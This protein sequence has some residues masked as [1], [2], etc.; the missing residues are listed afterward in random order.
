MN[1]ID[2]GTYNTVE[3]CAEACATIQECSLF[4]YGKI[5]ANGNKAGVDEGLSSLCLP[6]LLCTWNPCRYNNCQ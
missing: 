5:D 1:H 6:I 3:E 2:I 4:I